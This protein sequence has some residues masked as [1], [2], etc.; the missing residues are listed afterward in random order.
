MQISRF[1]NFTYLT[2]Y[3]HPDTDGAAGAS[4]FGFLVDNTP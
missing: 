1:D 2:D 4:C 3:H